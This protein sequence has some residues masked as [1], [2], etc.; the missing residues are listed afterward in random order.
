MK[1]KFSPIT[2]VL[3]AIFFVFSLSVFLFF[4]KVV[5][6][7]NEILQ[8]AHTEWQAETLRRNEIK[9]LD[10]SMKAIAQE[11]VMLDSHFA[12]SSDIVPFLNMIEELAS[13]VFVEA[14][15][16][17]VDIAK[18]NTSLTV[19]VKTSGSF[20]ALYKFLTL[21]EN[22]PF[23]L[24]FALVNMQRR[25]GQAVEGEAKIA[26]WEAFFKIKLLSFLP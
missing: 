13:S 5:N 6:D 17:S 25:S 10:R 23:E 15:I 11:R 19:G 16:S 14:E 2:L 26:R 24:E 22:S 4:Y 12:K 20:E 9:Q 3:S 18:D 21:L 1:I 7:K 8:Q